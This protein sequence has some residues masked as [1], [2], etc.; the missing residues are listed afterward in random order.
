MTTGGRG[1][2]ERAG[3]RNSEII[4]ESSVISKEEALKQIGVSL[5]CGVSSIVEA[6]HVGFEELVGM[7]RR[8]AQNIWPG[9][10]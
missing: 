4:G 5:R 6:P 10:A 7:I 1:C 9:D 3:S 8:V 2:A